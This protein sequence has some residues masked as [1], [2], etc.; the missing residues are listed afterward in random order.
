MKQIIFK[1]LCLTAFVMLA[2]ACSKQQDKPVQTQNS[3]TIRDY[4]G[5]D[6]TIARNPRRIV[7][8]SPGITEL[9][10][11]LK[12]QQRLVGRTDFCLYP[13]EAKNIPSVGG[14]SDASLELI[15][16]LR[17]DLVITASMVS[18]QMIE[19]MEKSGLKVI[20]LPEQKK[21]AD[22]YST[23]SVLGEIVGKK[24]IADS[25]I[26]D[27]KAKL[28]QITT[29]IPQG[30]KPLV[31]YVAGFGAGGDFTAG[32]NTFIND[33]IELSGG[34]NLAKQID[35][36]S[37]G[38]EE[39]FFRQ[40]EYIVIRKEDAETFKHTAPY[41][42]LSAVQEDRVLAIESTLTDC[43]TLRFVQAVRLISQFIHKRE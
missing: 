9:L 21:A 11:D 18:K 43:Q 38:K 39:I 6:V 40:P 1:L 22:V 30:K 16:S 36:W 34:E 3:I 33:I 27:C 7:S 12:E 31:Y 37:I 28:E 29:N 23:L 26:A 42:K 13:A 41:D 15:C 32:G 19:A 20:C 25:L 10:F 24:D 14:I 35:G 8:L 17:P 4:Y 5:R 2:F